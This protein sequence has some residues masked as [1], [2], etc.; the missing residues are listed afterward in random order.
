GVRVPTCLPSFRMAFLYILHSDSTGRYYIG[1][2]SDLERR[3]REHQRGQ[4]PSTR[5]R[6]PWRLIYREEFPTLSAA[7]KR[8]RQI[9]SWKSH[10][11]VTDLIGTS[12]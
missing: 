8:E 7:R 4:T 2:T 5:G 12:L 6:G 1:S 9:K 11:S 3:L 10:R